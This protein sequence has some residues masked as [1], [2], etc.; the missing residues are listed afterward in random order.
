MYGKDD[1][2]TPEQFEAEYASGQPVGVVPTSPII[3]LVGDDD[4]LTLGGGRIVGR[5]Q[6]FSVV[7]G[8]QRRISSM[9]GVDLL[10]WNGAS[11]GFPATV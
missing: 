1:E 6:S 9:S 4:V 2:M 7:I 3:I 8:E 10:K 11:R 5:S